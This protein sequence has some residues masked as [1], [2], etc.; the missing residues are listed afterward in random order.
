MHFCVFLI[1]YVKLHVRY[2]LSNPITII[3]LLKFQPLLYNIFYEL[4]LEGIDFF[5]ISSKDQLKHLFYETR[6]SL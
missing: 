2:S 1:Y 5:I 6:G 4:H 3:H